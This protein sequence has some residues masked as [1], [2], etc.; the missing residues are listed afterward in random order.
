MYLVSISIIPGKISVRKE[1]LFASDRCR[2]QS[3]EG[4]S[5]LPNVIQKA[6][7]ELGLE[8]RSIR[9]LSLI[10]PKRPKAQGK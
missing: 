3:S 1:L 4:L 5:D 6:S 7:A 2:N 9:C 10:V 8:S